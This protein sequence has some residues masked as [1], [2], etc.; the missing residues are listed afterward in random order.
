MD[1]TPVPD[2]ANKDLMRF[3]TD[4]E[5]LK[6]DLFNR[7]TEVGDKPTPVKVEKELAGIERKYSALAAIEAVENAGGTAH[8]YSVNLTD[9]AA[10]SAAIE[11]IK[12]KAEKIDV[13]LHA[14]G[15]EIS[16][17]LPDKSPQEFDLVFDVKA[18]GWYNLLSA[19]GEFPVAATVAF[20]SI[21]GRFG[22]AGQT[23]YSAAND[24]LCKSATSFRTSRR[25]TRGIALDWTAWKDIGMAARGSIPTV[26]KQAGI[27]MLPPEAGIPFI[28]KELT[29]GTRGLEVV[30]AQSLGRMVE[31]F[32]QAGGL[33]L[34]K[35][36]PVHTQVRQA[37]GVMAQE[38]VGMGLYDGLV[39]KGLL[40][41]HKQGFLFD[42]Q[43]NDT[44][45]LPGVMGVEAM[46]EA[47]SLLFPDLNVVAV[48]EVDFFA[49]FKFYRS[50][51]R[52]VS[53]KVNYKA[54]GEEILAFCELL[55]SRKLMGYSE[56]EV[57][58]HFKAKVR[59]SKSLLEAPAPITQKL[60]ATS[61][62]T[63]AQ[64]EDIYKLYFH[65]PAYQVL[66]KAWKKGDDLVGLYAGTLPPNHEPA[67]LQT[68]AAPRFVELCFQTAGIG[69]M[70]VEGRMGLP[71]HIDK[72][73]IFRQPAENG[74]L[75]YFAL[76]SQHGKA[77]NALVLD[78]KG[79]VYLKLEGYKTVEF[80]SEFD[81][82]LLKPLQ[83]VVK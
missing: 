76:L 45:V 7:M 39:V 14:G 43:I 20:S 55:G 37:K 23:D 22:N 70:G 36:A 46:L 79:E 35:E 3:A 68:K 19:L 9:P 52:E 12:K 66:E 1:L 73:L 51:P 26:M 29:S 74:K 16:R 44:P 2:K 56:E 41:P 34:K 42:H 33:D 65:G 4:R 18:D 47:A 38:V 28:R 27:D 77:W 13:L 62:D 80:I 54:E 30:V 72:L 78:G 83:A 82:S 10:V 58:T 48:E 69:E 5:G 60:S 67:E 40:D 8:Y 64:A 53:V 25:Q 59:L 81:K 24:F 50:E 57:K 17:L 31:E 11:D 6:R 21:A 15:L 61:K 75:K 32:D 71:M 49:P 63:T